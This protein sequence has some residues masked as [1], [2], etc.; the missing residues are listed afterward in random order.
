MPAGCQTPRAAPCPRSAMMQNG[1]IATGG[2][3]PTIRWLTLAVPDRQAEPAREPDQRAAQRPVAHRARRHV[4]AMRP[5]PSDLAGRE[6]L[7]RLKPAAR[8]PSAA[9]V[10]QACRRRSKTASTPPAP[11][12]RGLRA[13]SGRSVGSALVRL[14]V[15]QV[16]FTSASAT[17]GSSFGEREEPEQE[18][19]ER[20]G[21]DAPLHPGRHVGAPV[22]RQEVVR[23][24]GRLTM[25]YRSSHMP[26]LTSSD[27]DEQPA[28]VRARTRAEQERQRHEHVEHGQHP[29]DG[30][31]PAGRP[32]A[33]ELP[34]EDVAA[35]YQAMNGSTM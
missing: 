16:S 31:D 22:V 24:G 32:P 13:R 7:D 26:T 23:G 28:D 8:A 6:G 15:A 34:L 14:L 27:D 9:A 29:V 33:D 11:A 5:P 2:L 17:A 4:P 35:E 21:R 10:E 12:R 18:E 3:P 20:P 30:G 1:T 25:T 19:G